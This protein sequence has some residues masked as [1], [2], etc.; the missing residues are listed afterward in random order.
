[1]KIQ[2][3]LASDFLFLFLLQH[4]HIAFA[5]GWPTAVLPLAIKYTVV[6]K[7]RSPVVGVA[8]L[9]GLTVQAQCLSGHSHYPPPQPP[10][11]LSL[12]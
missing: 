5:G 11:Q 6:A 3:H 4:V 1:M 2:V 12:H 7:W 9:D 8:G 10:A